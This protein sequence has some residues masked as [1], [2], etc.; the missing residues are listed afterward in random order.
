MHFP[1]VFF[2]PLGLDTR[3][4]L[5]QT[6]LDKNLVS[7]AFSHL[8]LTP[9]LPFFYTSGPVL[10]NLYY[11]NLLSPVCDQSGAAAQ[12]YSSLPSLSQLMRLD[13]NSSLCD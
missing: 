5:F 3:I 4:T 10:N 6:D 1:F 9:C 8:V 7:Q 12:S 11:F 2:S 13:E